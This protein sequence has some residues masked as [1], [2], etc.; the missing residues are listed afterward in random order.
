MTAMM[1]CLAR[2]L[3]KSSVDVLSCDAIDECLL[4]VIVKWS[5]CNGNARFGRAVMSQ[6]WVLHARLRNRASTLGLAGFHAL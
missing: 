5:V 1:Y 2:L 6:M 3:V 4:R